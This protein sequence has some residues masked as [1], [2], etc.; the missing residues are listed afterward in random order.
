VHVCGGGVSRLAGVDDDHGPA[1][2][3]ELECGRKPGGRSAD[4]GDVTVPLDDAGGVV[5]HGL[6]DKAS[7]A[8]CRL[9]C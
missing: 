5:T 2:A 7:R 4:D 3:S 6:D 9:P 1:L 8:R